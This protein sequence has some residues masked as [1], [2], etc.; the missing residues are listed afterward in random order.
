MIH[1]TGKYKCKD[2]DGDEHI[3]LS[4][5]YWD[6]GLNKNIR[7]Y[8]IELSGHYIKDKNGLS[9]GYYP[10]TYLT[11]GEMDIELDLESKVEI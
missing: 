11:A 3:V 1:I 5:V 4:V 6:T 2:T 8:F 9:N 7:K 10:T